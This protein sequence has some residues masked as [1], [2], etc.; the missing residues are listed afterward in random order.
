MKTI[1][2]SFTI[3]NSSV[4]EFFLEL[5]NQLALNYKVIIITYAVEKSDFHISPRIE[6]IKWPS[7]RPTKF[8]DF[9]FLSK[10]IIKHKPEVMIANFGAVNMFLLAG[11]L[12]GVKQRIAWYHTLSAQL[13]KR[14]ILQYRK[15]IFYK[16]ATQIVANSK[17]TQDDLIKNFGVEKSK[18]KVIYNAVKKSVLLNNVIPYKLVYAGRMHKTKG[19]DTLIQ[20]IPFV[21]KKFPLVNLTLLGDDLKGEQIK[22]Y[23]EI[24]NKLEVQNNVNFIGNQNKDKVLEQFSSAYITIVP[25]VVEAFGYVVIESFSVKTPVIGSN[26]SG[27]AEIIRND[28]DGY[29]FEV[30][31]HK[32]LSDKINHLLGNPR[33]REQFSNNCFERFLE[34]F[35]VKGVVN[36]FR[37]EFK[38]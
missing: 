7:K 6:V 27:I 17:A 5:S 34:N 19:V 15:K 32:D 37:E 16:M 38:L 29:L 31:N 36:N 28:R 20:A 30:N 10:L 4:A 23:I 24:V 9:I 21:V 18:V 1:F 12:L 25:S 13:E 26:T 11:Y 33:L 2:L 35:E 14:K 22:K 8:K 3:K